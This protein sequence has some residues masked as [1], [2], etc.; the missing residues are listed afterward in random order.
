MIQG[1]TLEAAFADLLDVKAKANL[2]AR[3]AAYVCLSR[4]KTMNRIVVLQAFNPQLFTQGPPAGPARLMEKLSGQKTIRE[5]ANSWMEDED[6][7]KKNDE[8]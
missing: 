4:V 3:I 6:T 2:T 8:N 5:V 1:A 7:D